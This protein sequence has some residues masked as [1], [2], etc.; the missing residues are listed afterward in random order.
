MLI[1][2][3]RPG[4]VVHVGGEV[5]ITILAIT[6]NQVRIGFDAPRTIPVDRAEI[7]ERKRRDLRRTRSILKHGVLQNE[8]MVAEAA[9]DL[10]SAHPEVALC[11]TG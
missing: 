2:K 6:G 8:A 10:V 11:D 7:V 4:Q 9:S 3:R 5:K 1:L